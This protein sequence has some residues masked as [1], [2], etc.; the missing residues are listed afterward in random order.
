MC[1]VKISRQKIDDL[2]IQVSIDVQKAIN[3]IW[4]NFLTTKKKKNEY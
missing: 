3:R 4:F 2:E 1:E